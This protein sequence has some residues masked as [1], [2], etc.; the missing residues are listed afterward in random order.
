MITL[1]L[2]SLVVKLNDVCRNALEDAAG[3]CLSRTH[4][5]VEIEHWLL[6][7]LSS[8]NTDINLILSK[9]DINSTNVITHLNRE[10]DHLRSGNSRSPALSP[11]IVDLVKNSWMLASVEYKHQQ[12]T[13]AHL[14]GALLLDET[15]R[16]STDIVNGELRKIN[17]EALREFIGAVV[18]HTAE[19]SHASHASEV[20]S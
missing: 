11:T 12:I 1:D 18:G 13:S 14:L 20:K 16:R 9:F 6:K 15:L 3:L 5:N 17:P 10:L 4:Y 19:S 2:K 7:I 8:Q